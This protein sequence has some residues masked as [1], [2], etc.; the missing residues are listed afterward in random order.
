MQKHLTKQQV[1]A[2]RSRVLADSLKYG[3]TTT[4]RRY[5]IHRDTIY[6]WKKE[7]LPQ[8]PGPRGRVFWQTDENTEIIILQLRL[9]TGHGPKRLH[10]E[11]KDM[12]IVVGEKAIRGVIKRAGLVKAQRKPR[13]KASQP[14][15]AP[16]PGYRLQVDTK[17]MP[18]GMDKRSTDRYQ[19]T[20]IDIVSKIRFLAVY[21]Y[22]SNGNSIAFVRHA[23]AFYADIGIKIDC[24]QTDNHASF[25]NLYSG[26]TKKAD[27]QLRRVHPLTIFL[28]DQGIEHKLS[29]P[30]TPQHNGFVERSHRTDEEEFYGITNVVGLDDASLATK[31]QRW[32]DEYNLERLHSS[33]NYLPPMEYFT[34]MWKERLVNE[35]VSVL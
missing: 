11:L 30:A 1:I 14:F 27:H 35:R 2:Y 16:Y 12:G 34:R 7:L 22:L 4:A 31:L 33:C 17:A 23:L 25:T 29:R 28:T 20:A 15:Y 19:F 18:R 3:P 9:G 26:G 10:A 13:K 5:G 24:V 21:N 32:Q 8:K 6:A